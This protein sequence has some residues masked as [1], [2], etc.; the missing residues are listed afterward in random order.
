LTM[1][2]GSTRIHGDFY[3]F[4]RN[5]ALDAN[6]WNNN[7]A[8]AVKNLDLQSDF[9]ALISGPVVIPK[10]YN[11][12]DK[13]FFMFDYEGFR[14]HTGN[15]SVASFPDADF[16]KGNLSALCT[17]AASFNGA[18]IC[19]DSSAQLYDPTTHTPIPFDTLTNDPNYTESAVMSKVFA[20]IPATNGNP[21]SNVL[22]R[23]NTTIP[24]NMFDVKID[25]N[26]S[27]RQRISF[28][29][30]YDNTNNGS[31]ETI[32]VIFGG[33]TP[34]RT[35][36][37]RLSD[38]ITLTP[39]VLNHSLVGYSRRYRG[40]ISSS[41]G[42]GYPSKLGITGVNNNTFPCFNFL[43]TPYGQE[44]SNC[45][46]SEFADNVAEFADSVGW[47][48]GKHSFKFGGEV[49]DME[50]NVRRLTNGAGSFTFSPVQTS[51]TG[52]SSGL[53]GNAI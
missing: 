46:D 45:G 24:A 7:T 52:S 33:Q 17:G 37:L 20:Y 43:N 12:R 9:G 49:R 34:Q 48:H 15:S 10:I 18:G 40:E 13:T 14:F 50:F 38:D 36:Y 2:S 3:E 19:S 41:L 8:G 28:G 21:T 29:L 23:G 51:S 1:K 25:Q 11:G 26:I 44:L 47:V 32:G 6:S 42:G 4:Q 16:L 53:G 22:V 27:S 5:S 30:D 31:T 39:S 35:R